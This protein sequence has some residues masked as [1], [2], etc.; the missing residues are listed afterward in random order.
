MTTEKPVPSRRQ[1]RAVCGEIGPEDG[2]DPRLPVRARRRPG[3]RRPAASAPPEPGRKARQLASQVFETLGGVLA[4]D[5]GDD[6]LGAL[7]VVSVEPAPDASRLLVSLALLPPADAV[8]PDELRARLARA[9]GWL[10]TEVAAAVTRKRAP[11]LSFRLVP[12]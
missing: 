11:R 1:M 12:N 9:A 4:G 2:V 10:R 5:T 6:L 8:D 3:A 7:R